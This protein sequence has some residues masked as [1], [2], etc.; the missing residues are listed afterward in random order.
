[1]AGQKCGFHPI[2]SLPTVASFFGNCPSTSFF[3]LSLGVTLDL[4]R[5]VALGVSSVQPGTVTVQSEIWCCVDGPLRIFQ[6]IILY[7]NPIFYFTN[8]VF[9]R[10]EKVHLSFLLIRT[11]PLSHK[12]CESEKWKSLS[13]VRS[14]VHGILQARILEW[15]ALLFSRGSSQPRDQTQVYRIAGGFLTNWATRE[16]L[17]NLGFEIPS[18]ESFVEVRACLWPQTASLS[19]SCAE[20]PVTV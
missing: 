16:A 18:V 15:V 20:W 13:H 8:W 5:V 1:M 19:P 3:W 6:V 4:G 7:S 12:V 14:L 10:A 11:S 2:C 17:V 9:V